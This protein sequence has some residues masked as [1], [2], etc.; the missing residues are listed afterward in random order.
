M[1]KLI[2]P[3][4][5]LAIVGLG[6]GAVMRFGSSPNASQTVAGSLAQPQSLVVG[7]AVDG[8]TCE[9]GEMLTYHV[10]THLDIIVN[11]QAA[12]IPAGI[13]IGRPWSV[14]PTGFVSGGSCFSWLHTHDTTGIIHIEASAEQKF[15]LGQLFAVWGIPLSNSCIASHC[16]DAQN[17]LQ[18]YVNGQLASGNPADITLNPHDEITIIYGTTTQAPK[19]IPTSY[20]FPQGL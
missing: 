10:H 9:A 7:K 18:I 15:T 16:T 19:T 2:L 4:I 8:I 5:M 1:R 14:D 20:N 12:T 17:S 13:G 11:G 6:V 3:I